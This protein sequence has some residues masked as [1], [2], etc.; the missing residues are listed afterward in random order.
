MRLGSWKTIEEA[1][2]EGTLEFVIGPFFSTVTGQFPWVNDKRRLVRKTPRRFEDSASYR[3]R[4]HH[5][6]RPDA[7]A[8]TE[9]KWRWRSWTQRVDTN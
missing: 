8:W 6:H 7:K 2:Q 3:P 1:P 4:R 5:Q 9:V